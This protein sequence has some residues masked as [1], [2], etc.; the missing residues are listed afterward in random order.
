MVINPLSGLLHYTW[1]ANIFRML[2]VGTLKRYVSSSTSG[3]E[4]DSSIK[5]KNMEETKATSARFLTFVSQSIAFETGGDKSGGY[6]N[7]PKDAGGETKW[8]ISKRAHP[9][10]NIK[11]LTYSQAVDTYK[12][13]YWNDLY[14]YILS[15]AI[16]Y[17]LFDMGILCGKSTSVKILQKGIVSN[18]Y[19]IACDG[20]FGVITLTAVNNLKPELFYDSYI[21]ALEKRFRRIVFLKPW[22][23]R[24]LNGWLRRNN[25]KWQI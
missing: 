23:K 5:E 8:G 24:F 2:G 20:N 10:L 25:W 11:A 15:D 6:T 18:G 1:M 3:Q 12:T 22:N 14:D 17:K 16:A 4:S 7:D 9:Q 21:T 19:T 13:Q